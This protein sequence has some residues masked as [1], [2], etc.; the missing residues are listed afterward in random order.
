MTADDHRRRA[1]PSGPGASA[2]GSRSRCPALLAYVPLL[3]TQPGQVGADTKT[4]LYLNPGKVLAEAPYVWNSQ[5][6]M[7]T[8]THQYIGYLWPMGPFYWVFQQVG[9]PDWVAQR[10]WIGTVMLAAGLGVRYLCRTLGLGHRRGH[11]GRA[12][13][14]QGGVGRHPRRQP[15]LHVQPVP[16]RVRGA[17]LGDPAALG[18]PALDDRADG[19]GPAPRR[20]ALPGAVRPGRADRRRHQRHRADHDRHRATALCGVGRVRRARGHR[21]RGAGGHGP[22]GCAHGA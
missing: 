7:G 22:H 20:L 12:H 5:I 9:V 14:R 11:R 16:A 15:R 13:R 4:Y 6:G 21:A 3:L 18:G 2:H 17:H 8:V 19:T 10:I 1:R